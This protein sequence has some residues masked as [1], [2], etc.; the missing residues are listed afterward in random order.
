MQ[1]YIVERD[2]PGFTSDQLPAAA[3]KGKAAAA[4]LTQE[5]TPVRYLRSMFMPTEQ[6]SFCMYEAESPAAVKQAQERAGLPF[7]RI[8]EGVQISAEEVG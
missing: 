6:K 4:Q 8:V 7:T 3:A 2:L 5:G 1:R